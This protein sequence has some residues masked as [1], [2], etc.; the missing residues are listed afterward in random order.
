MRRF[1]EVGLSNVNAG[2]FSLQ[3]GNFL[4]RENAT[5]AAIQA[6]DIAANH[7]LGPVRTIPGRDHVGRRRYVVQFGH[8]N[9]RGAAAS[10]RKRMG[11]LDYIVAP[12]ADAAP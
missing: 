2:V 11:R 7:R 9:S 5:R 3:V 12:R 4:E 6:R 1:E 8:F 10:A